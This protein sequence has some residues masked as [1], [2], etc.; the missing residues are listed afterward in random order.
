MEGCL[1]ADLGK[2]MPTNVGVSRR[3][4]WLLCEVG[5][6]TASQGKSEINPIGLFGATDGDDNRR[7]EDE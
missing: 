4:V 2:Q 3:R 1:N 6:G 5:G 7:A